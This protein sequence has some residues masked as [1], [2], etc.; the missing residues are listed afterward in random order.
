M[1]YGRLGY[2][3]FHLR[4]AQLGRLTDLARFLITTILKV[5]KELFCFLAAFFGVLAHQAG[6]LHR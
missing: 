5:F 4:V 3:S 6:S 1:E 2:C